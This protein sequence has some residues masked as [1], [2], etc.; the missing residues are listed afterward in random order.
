MSVTI[1]DPALVAALTAG[2]RSVELRDATGRVIGTL[3]VRDPNEPLVPWDPSITAEELDRRA[4]GPGLSF[5]EMRKR[6]G[7]E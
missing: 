3:A 2:P 6:L 1:T 7:W 5:E 4:N